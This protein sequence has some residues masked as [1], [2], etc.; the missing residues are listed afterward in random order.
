MNPV[1]PSA[2]LLPR[3]AALLYDL[4]IVLGLLLVVGL[5]AQLV[6]QAQL[7]RVQ[8]GHAQVPAAYQAL[9]MTLVLAYFVVSWRL[10]GQTLGARAWRLRVVDARQ[11]PPGWA[12]ALLRALWAAAPLLTLALAPLLPLRVVLALPLALWLA[13][14]AALLV[15]HPR[16]T[17][18]DRFSGTQLVARPR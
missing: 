2:P 9:Q 13:D 11:R 6:T 15:A 16:R 4:L 17:L 3:L 18:H 14:Y 8:Q 5:L 12:R 7:V 10:G 1:A